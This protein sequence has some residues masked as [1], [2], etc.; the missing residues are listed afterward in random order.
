MLSFSLLHIY[1]FSCLISH[2]LPHF[3]LLFSI[4]PA[5]SL[6]LSHVFTGF[7]FFYPPICIH[8]FFFLASF[9]W[10]H[11]FLSF[12]LNF[13]NI[14]WQ[15]SLYCT[16]ITLLDQLSYNQQRKRCRSTIY[17]IYNL[18]LYTHQID[19]KFVIAVC[20]IYIY[21]KHITNKLYIYV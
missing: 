6:S 12:F 10:L 16:S 14:H 4:S 13:L 8:A 20:S 17:D 11:T 15:S 2:Y 18:R 9:P 19:I 5:P 7:Y 1:S 3:P 21:T